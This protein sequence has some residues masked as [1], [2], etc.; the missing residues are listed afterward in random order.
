MSRVKKN[1]FR[2]RLSAAESAVERALEAF[3]RAADALDTAAEDAAAVVSEVETEVQRLT[4]VRDEAYR[5]QSTYTDRA[6]KIRE[7]VR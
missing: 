2:G 1:S 7:L 3:Q 4:T 5:Q 6:A